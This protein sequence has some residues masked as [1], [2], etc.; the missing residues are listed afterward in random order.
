MTEACK[1]CRR[2]MTPMFFG[3]L[4]ED[5]TDEDVEEMRRWLDKKLALD[6]E[7]AKRGI[8]MRLHADDFA[9]RQWLWQ[10]DRRK[11]SERAEHQAGMLL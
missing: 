2:E 9:A 5:M 10:R 7:Y 4:C 6:R 3:R 11:E 1:C 8:A